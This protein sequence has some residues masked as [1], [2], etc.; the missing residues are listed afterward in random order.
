V[1]RFRTPENPGDGKMPIASA[2]S[3]RYRYGND[4]WV[5]D[6]SY[7]WL[8][9]ITLGYN[10]PESLFNN[11][12]VIK[13]ARFYLTAQNTFLLSKNKWGMPEASQEGGNTATLQ[14][15][16]H[17]SYPIPMSF[18]VGANITF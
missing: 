18:T 11:Q 4:N 7:L 2:A 6:N 10:L 13:N 12:N 16:D 9:N 14:G 17:N 15:I 5:Q 3:I 1:K 8:R